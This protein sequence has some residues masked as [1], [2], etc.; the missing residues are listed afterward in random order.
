MGFR[1]FQIT[2]SVALPLSF[3]SISSRGRIKSAVCLHA[4]GLVLHTLAV[5][6]STEQ[7]VQPSAR[8]LPGPAQVPNGASTCRRLSRNPLLCWTRARG[9][10]SARHGT[11][12]PAGMHCST[13]RDMRC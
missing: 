6:V 1:A 4:D 8:G 2:P 13:C 3:T 12:P 10:H 5:V 7:T 9:H 11:S